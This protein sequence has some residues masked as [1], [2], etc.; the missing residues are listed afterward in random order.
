MSE[1]I[2]SAMVLAAGLGTRM[3]PLTLDRPKP[4][5]VLNRKTLLDHVLDRLVEA[6][7]GRAV[8]NVHYYADLIEKAVAG[9]HAPQ[10]QI[11]DERDALL[12]TGG[13]VT[14]ALPLLGDKPFFVHNSDSVWIEG[15]KSNLSRM[16][17]AWDDQHMDCLMLVAPTQSSLGVTSR[18]DFIMQQDGTLMR[19]GKQGAAPFVFTGVSIAHPRMFDGAP[20]GSFS[21]NMLWDQGIARG[22]LFGICLDGLWMHVGTPEALEDAERAMEKSFVT[23]AVHI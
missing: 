7:I 2:E 8:I 19:C 23:Q 13:G 4:L 10:I 17:Q 15:A 3:R 20:G 22:R 14:R 18:G 16:M 1:H 9:R 5:V 21:L 12:D 11:S 6:G